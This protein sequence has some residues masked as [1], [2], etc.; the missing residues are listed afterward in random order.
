MV[1]IKIEEPSKGKVIAVEEEMTFMPEEDLQTYF[2]I[3]E[4]LQLPKEM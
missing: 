4:A 1:E 3:E 2:S